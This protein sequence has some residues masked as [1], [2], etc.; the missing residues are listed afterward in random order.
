M[1]WYNLYKKNPYLLKPK[2]ICV[3]LQFKTLDWDFVPKII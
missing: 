3:C 2:L 1:R